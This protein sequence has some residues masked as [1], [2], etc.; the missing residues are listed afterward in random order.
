MLCYTM[1]SEIERLCIVNVRELVQS[2]A[3]NLK[4]FPWGF[5]TGTE[6]TA[7]T[8]ASQNIGTYGFLPVRT[9]RRSVPRR[10]YPVNL[11]RESACYRLV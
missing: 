2:V 7:F 3:A 6:Q 10:C 4:E 5:C 9:Y 8:K 11:K 1:S